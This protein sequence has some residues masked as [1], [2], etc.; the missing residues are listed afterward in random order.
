MITALMATIP[1]REEI[2]QTVLKSIYNQV[3]KIMIVFNKYARIP[4]WL[5][6]FDTENKIHAEAD[7]SN[8]QSDCAKWRFLD[9]CEGYVFS[10]DDDILYPTN[11]VSKMISK[12]EETKRKYVLTVHGSYFHKPFVE[13]RKSKRCIHFTAELSK[14][15]FV[16]MLGSGTTAFHTDTFYIDKNIQLKPNRSDLQLSILIFKQDKKILCVE[17]KGSWLTPLFTTGDTI[18]DRSRKDL[19]LRA[20]LNKE[21]REQLLPL[22]EKQI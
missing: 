21:I 20:E 3:D 4:D 9:K 18:W 8:V 1:E 19:K 15:I 11:Y 6:K 7:L 16:S 22:L 2:V 13:F 10:I 17:R 14:D 5:L 12:I